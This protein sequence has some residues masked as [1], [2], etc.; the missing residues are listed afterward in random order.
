MGKSPSP[1]ACGD[2]CPVVGMTYFDVLEY[3]NRKSRTEGLE[4]CYSLGSCSAANVDFGRMCE[5]AVFV[6]PDCSGYRLPSE[7]EWELAANAGSQSCMDSAPWAV[8]PV[9]PEQGCDTS[10]ESRALPAWYCA[11]SVVTYE[12]CTSVGGIPGKCHGPSGVGTKSA[13]AYGLHDMH[14]NVGEFTGSLYTWPMKWPGP[15]YPH[16]AVVD[17]G[18]DLDLMAKPEN[19]IPPPF[20]VVRGGSFA[21]LLASV[22]AASRVGWRGT[23]DDPPTVGFR[24]VRTTFRN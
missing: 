11:N 23:L 4:E 9:A 12:G 18:F 8:L 15:P 10:E 3:A 17:H 19:D 16:S 21:N 24:L 20:V 22:C 14:G 6:G 13:N 1:Y 5:S 7:F 2:N